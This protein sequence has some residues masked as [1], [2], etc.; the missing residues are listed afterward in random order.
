MEVSNGVD[1]K[2]I[3]LMITGGLIFALAVISMNSARAAARKNAALKTYADS[4]IAASK[5]QAV[6]PLIDKAKDKIEESLSSVIGRDPFKR[7]S[8]AEDMSL[9]YKKRKIESI[10]GILLTGIVYDTGGMRGNFCI[11]NGEE[12]RVKDKIGD[13]VITGIKENQ[14][15]LI[16]EKEQK[17]YNLKLWED[18]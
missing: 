11:I 15:T 13:F 4:K 7:Q 3:Q 2:K 14:V 16:N 10:A 1:K 9:D 18:Q 5:P 17:E 8:V 6:Q 12:A